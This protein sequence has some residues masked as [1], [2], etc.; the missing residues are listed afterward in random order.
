MALMTKLKHVDLLADGSLRYRRRIPLV[1][2]EA[3]GKK[4]FQQR[5]QSKE[6]ADLIKEYAEIES[7]YE[8]MV[9]QRLVR[10]RKE[11]LWGNTPRETFKAAKVSSESV[12]EGVRGLDRDDPEDR[13]LVAA[14]LKDEG[15][16]K[17]ILN[18]NK[19]EP[20][21]TLKDALKLYRKERVKDD[22][23]METRITRVWSEVEEAIGDLPLDEL[24]RENARKVRD[25]MISVEKYGGGNRSAAT[26]KRM[27]NVV[28]AVVSF[29]LV[30]FDLGDKT[31]PFIGL[32]VDD[33]GDR[34]DTKR[35]PLPDDLTERLRASLRGDL[36]HI[37]TILDETGARVGE[38]VGLEG[39]DLFLDHETPYIHIRPNTTRRLKTDSSNR[40]VPLTDA[41]QK[42]FK[43]ALKEAETGGPIWPQ[44]SRPRGSDSASAALMKNLRKLT[45]D[46]KFTIHSLRHRFKDR[47][48]D[49]GMPKNI[50]DQLLGHSSVDVGE[51]VYGSPEAKLRLAAQWIEKLT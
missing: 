2:Q 32:K 39:A 1:A 10:A 48:R 16:K 9:A 49:V 20:K 27:L 22:A 36:A 28:K 29:G 14:S 44:Y 26:V 51:R 17:L 6:G 37:M 25:H 11:A 38:I 15:V 13:H 30:E 50:Q 47:C 8:Q 18:P 24:K 7:L 40:M 34:E 21:P 45:K 5:L 23:A 3:V 19:T 43:A 41:A 4:V 33:Q 31:N 35:L 46:R 42:S 12:W